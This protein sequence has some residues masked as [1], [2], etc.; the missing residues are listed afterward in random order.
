MS[1][2]EIKTFEEF[3]AKLMGFFDAIIT[4]IKNALGIKIDVGATETMDIGNINF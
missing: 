2:S 4:F 1:N 3:W